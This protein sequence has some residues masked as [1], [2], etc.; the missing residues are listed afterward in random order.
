MPIELS[1]LLPDTILLSRWSGEI[2]EH[3]MQVLV[4][5]L[6]IIL[7]TAPRLIHTLIELSEARHIQSEAAYYYFR[8]RIPTHPHRGRV[9]LVQAPF[10]GAA[11]ADVFNRVSGRELFRIFNTRDEAYDFL[12]RHD[13]PPP[14]ATSQD[15][16]LNN[17]DS[18]ASDHTPSE[19]PGE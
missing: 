2:T 7:D 12:R 8:S 11:L 16:S 15:H 18:S 10:Q 9:A 14:D 19:L 4:E 17:T 6:G 13:T 5:E 3:D 1:W